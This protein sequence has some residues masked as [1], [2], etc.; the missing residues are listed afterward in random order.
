VAGD[1]P[2]PSVFSAIQV[3]YTITESSL[4]ILLESLL[5]R[6]LESFFKSL[7]ENLLDRVLHQEE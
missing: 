5:A 7:V 6:L 3:L 2:I 4:E 1:R